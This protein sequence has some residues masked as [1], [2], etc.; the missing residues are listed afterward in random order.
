MV[1]AFDWVYAE[2]TPYLREQ[3]ARYA[4]YVESFADELSGQ[5]QS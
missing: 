4:E 1:E 3:Q 2:Q 5:G